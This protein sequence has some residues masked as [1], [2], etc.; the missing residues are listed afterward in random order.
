VF[1]PFVMGWFQNGEEPLDSARNFH[2][3]GIVNRAFLQILR[4]T[5]RSNHITLEI[6]RR[7]RL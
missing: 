1:C 2:P 5:E 6:L 7:I 4:V 3:C